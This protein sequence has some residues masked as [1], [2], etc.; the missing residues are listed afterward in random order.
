MK[1]APFKYYA[2]SS[3]DEA[4]ARL[5]EHGWD[6][7]VLAGGQSLV[8][9]MNF[10]LAQPAVLVDLNGISELFYIQPGRRGSLKI[11]AMT[12][13]R[14]VELDPSV[15]ERAPMLGAALPKVAYPQIRSR[16]TL[17]GSIAHADPSAELV[18]LSV[19]LDS[20]LR[21]RSKQRGERWV[22][23]TDFY[24]G[25]FTTVLEP[26]E[27]LVEVELPPMPQRSG[28]SFM[29]VARRHHDFALVGVAA[30]VTL[31]RARNKCEQARLVY[32]SVGDGPVEAHQAA[33][34]LQGQEPTLEA[35]LEAAETA[36]KQDV[37]PNSDIN[38]SA[39]YR[40]HLVKVLGQRALTEAV[41]RARTGK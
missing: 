26:D 22:A 40:R 18:A 27:L 11:G 38:A 1:P 28:W 30:V 36:G 31:N 8:P 29:E 12:R 32:F 23:A 35:I 10:R 4:L 17:G 37:D 14:Q 5:A 3:V 33:A 25:L 24:L 15:A 41:E 16:G 19:A 21:L 20:R 2:P 39:E 13:Q 7:K 9:M 6:A 34:V